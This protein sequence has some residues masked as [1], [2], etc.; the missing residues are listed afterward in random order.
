MA[1]DTLKTGLIYIFRFESISLCPYRRR[2]L[3]QRRGIKTSRRDGRRARK[4]Y[5]GELV[6]VELGHR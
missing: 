3:E 2:C 4:S 5:E 1:S 6:V